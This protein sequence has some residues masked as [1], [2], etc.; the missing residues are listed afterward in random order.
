MSKTN[1][2]SVVGIVMVGG[3]VSADQVSVRA[4]GTL[5]VHPVTSNSKSVP[6]GVS[7]QKSKM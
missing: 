3:L 5:I 7:G 6:G 2:P 1:I 4:H